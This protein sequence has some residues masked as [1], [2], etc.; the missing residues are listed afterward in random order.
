MYVDIVISNVFNWINIFSFSF[1][2]SFASV[3]PD[4]CSCEQQ[5]WNKTQTEKDGEKR[6]V[7]IER[8]TTLREFPAFCVCT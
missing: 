7:N 8:S 3:L 4:T 6:S 1:F 2:F 5:E